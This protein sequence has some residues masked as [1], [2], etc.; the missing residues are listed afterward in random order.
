[1]NGPEQPFLKNTS[2][3]LL[4]YYL[5]KEDWHLWNGD[6]IIDLVNLYIAKSLKNTCERV[7]FCLTHFFLISNRVAKGWDWDFGQNLSNCH[8]TDQAENLESKATALNG[9]CQ[10]EIMFTLDITLT[11]VLATLRLKSNFCP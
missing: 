3:W 7:P 4:Q 8:A 2:R 10:A 11:N 1:M 9:K 5:D 6:K